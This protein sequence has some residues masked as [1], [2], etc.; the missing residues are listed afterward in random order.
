MSYLLDILSQALILCGKGRVSSLEED[1]EDVAIAKDMVK[2]V[3]SICAIKG[4][5]GE[6]EKESH[7]NILP[8]A[9]QPF[10]DF[11]CYQL[12]SDFISI[13]DVFFANK[14]DRSLYSTV[15]A[16]GDDISSTY[17]CVNTP[18][19]YVFRGEYICLP[20]KS[21]NIVLRYISLPTKSKGI[22]MPLFTR[23]CAAQ[24]ALDIHAAVGAVDSLNRLMIHKESVDNEVAALSSQRTSYGRGKPFFSSM[25]R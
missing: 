14:D 3:V 18:L 7:I 5:F 6:F 12:P 11:Y 19:T 2:G 9:D 17:N 1:R 10:S 4:Y 13:R 20:V 15:S 22:N 16:F 24:L 23:Y 25:F 21:N 8:D